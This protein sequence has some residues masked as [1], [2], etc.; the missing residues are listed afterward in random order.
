MKYYKGYSTTVKKRVRKEYMGKY[1]VSYKPIIRDEVLVKMTKKSWAEWF[2]LLDANKAVEMSHT[3]KARFL[4]D[5][6]LPKNSWWCQMIV[7]NYE[8][9]R[10]I[11]HVRESQDGFSAS[12]TK[13]LPFSLVQVF[14]LFI[15]DSK[16]NTWFGGNN[17][18]VQKTIPNRLIRFLWVENKS[19]V[20]AL[21][22]DKSAT[23]S[24]I[25]IEHKKLKNEEEA[26]K[27]KQFWKKTLSDIQ[28]YI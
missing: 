7:A 18:V 4:Y 3:E 26:Q 2:S 24:Q 19:K 6:Y 23:K 14:S 12:V 16:R 25:T 11:K 10:G 21:F 20:T 28:D 1:V 17:T 5:Q 27:Y 8:R 22:T 13:I 15:T 9:A